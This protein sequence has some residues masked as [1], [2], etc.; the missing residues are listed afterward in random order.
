MFDWY[1][2]HRGA[3]EIV[4]QRSSFDEIGDVLKETFSRFGMQKAVVLEEIQQSWADIVGQDVSR[5]TRPSSVKADTVEVEVVNPAWMY[6]LDRE[7]KTTMEQNL[8]N[9][10]GSKV[11]NIRL[12]P[13]GRRPR[14]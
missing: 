2:T 14:E 3:E 5:V 6:I 9:Q 11:R 12:L 13:A 8:R 1:G 7:Y 10:T 4:A